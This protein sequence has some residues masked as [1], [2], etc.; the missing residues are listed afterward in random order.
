ME[1]PAER[2]HRLPRAP[3]ER[4]LELVVQLRVASADARKDPDFRDEAGREASRV[5]RDLQHASPAMAEGI[6]GDG[7]RD[8]Q[9]PAGPQRIE[10]DR[11]WMRGPRVH[12]D[13][14][15]GPGVVLATIP[16]VTTTWGRSLRLS[17]ARAARS[18]SSSMAVTCPWGPTTAARIAV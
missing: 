4:R 2:L 15:A 16:L 10:P 3:S 14:I 13:G 1:V 12:E 17:R 6:D 5:L 18:G 11:A 8:E 7:Q 9:P